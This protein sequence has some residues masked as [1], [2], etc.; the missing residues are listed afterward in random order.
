MAELPAEFPAEL[1][2]DH[3]APGAIWYRVTL[4]SG[5]TLDIPGPVGWGP[6][7][8][9]W[10]TLG[11]FLAVSGGWINLAHIVKVMPL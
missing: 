2:N 1:D 3:P 10:D 6:G 4:T 9:T 7:H 5:D 11:G 8:A